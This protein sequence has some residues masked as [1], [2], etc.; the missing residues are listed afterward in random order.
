M[1]ARADKHLE[2]GPAVLR[3]ERHDHTLSAFVR[4]DG[5]DWTPVGQFQE[6]LAQQLYVGVAAVNSTQGPFLAE[7]EDFTIFPPP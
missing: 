1:L 3:L 4:Q 2:E 6:D 5:K 7:F